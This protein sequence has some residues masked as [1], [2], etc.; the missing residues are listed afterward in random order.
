MFL[1]MTF[2]ID[3]RDL[4]IRLVTSVLL[5]VGWHFNK[6]TESKGITFHIFL[7]FLLSLLSP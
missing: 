6:S 1:F 4:K 3:S 2:C 7:V 5:N